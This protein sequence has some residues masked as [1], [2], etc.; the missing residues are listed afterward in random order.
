[1]WALTPLVAAAQVVT[2][3]PGD[4]AA[5]AAAGAT[6][7]ALAALDLRAAR[8]RWTDADEDALRDLAA[9]LDDA[10]P[11]EHVLDGERLILRDLEP[12]VAAVGALR[13]ERDRNALFA[14][15][16]YE[17]FA[18]DRYFGARLA[19]DP[20]AAPY[21]GRIAGLA[22]P[23]AW[24]DAAALAPDRAAS[25]YEIGEAPQRAA[26]EA[27]RAELAALAPAS[28]TPV[29]LPPGAQLVVDGVPA[30]PGPSGDVK[31]R[32]GRHLV[33]AELDGRIV[34]R[35]DVRLDIAED[36]PLP[37]EVGETAWQRFLADP[38]APPPEV[39]ALA[40]A[41]GG[42]VWVVR[43]DAPLVRLTGEGAVEVPLVP[44]RAEV[45]RRVGGALGVQGA[46]LTSG[47]FYLQDPRGAPRTVATV[48][49]LGP[50]V[51]AELRVPAGPLTVG[52]GAEVAVP[53][54]AH[55]VARTGD[56]AL[57]VRPL[58]YLSAGWG[59]VDVAVGFLLP[60]HAVGGLHLWLPLTPRVGL[61]A[62][63]WAGLPLAPP[64]PD[65]SR[66]EGAPVATASLGV[67]LRL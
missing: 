66:W 11:Y 6:G 18:A 12:A 55:H 41:S 61:R 62:A 23:R 38:A 56:G 60:Y 3:A 27:V 54:G 58:P 35:W 29:D 43:G 15:L 21:T 13:D 50:G 59:P 51:F 30:V 8:T 33:H 40:A 42:E 2:L 65:G 20:D 57:R 32:P 10:R 36:R 26:Y 46:W 37:P 14:A 52:A 1:M 44:V 25:P 16:L 49:A 28:L 31:V 67:G 17:G 22:V 5:I 63:G 4:P 9:A 48:N 39:I 7:P 53:L 19:D 64:R 45:P 34:A 24:L 47:D